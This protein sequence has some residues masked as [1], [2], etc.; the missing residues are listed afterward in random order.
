MEILSYKNNTKFCSKE[1][2]IKSPN[3]RK[4]FKHTQ[5]IIEKIKASGTLFKKGFTP[6]NKGL[7]GLKIGTP[8]GTKFSQEHRQKLS[9]TK[10]KYFANG[11]HPHNFK[12]NKEWENEVIRHSDQ[13]INWRQ[14]VY[15]KDNYTCQRCKKKSNK[16]IAHHIKSFSGYPELRFDINNGEVLCRGCHCKIHKSPKTINT[17]LSYVGESVLSYP[18]GIIE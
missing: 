14:F 6:W 7:K 3:K 18:P 11:R 17:G 10:Q 4:N 5:E 1:C 12:D 13:Y 9:E 16:I 15:S 2:W 8:K